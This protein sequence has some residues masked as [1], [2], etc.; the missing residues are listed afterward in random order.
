MPGIPQVYY[1]G[2]FGDDNDMDLLAKTNI[3]RDINRH[4]YS[5][6]EVRVKLASPMVQKLK[7][8]MLF[9]NNHPS[10]QGEFHLLDSPDEILEIRWVAGEEWSQLHIDLEKA[11]MRLEFS[12]WAGRSAIRCEA[13]AW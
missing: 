11:E 5:R 2:L 7:E 1:V 8:F 6:E 10:F 12:E 4:Y 3:G 13:S 9:R